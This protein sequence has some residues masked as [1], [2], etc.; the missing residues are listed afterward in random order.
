MIR[1]GVD[2]TN[3]G[4]GGTIKNLSNI[5]NYCEYKK[6]FSFYIWYS[7]NSNIKLIKKRKNVKLIKI[8][9][10]NFLYRLIWQFFFFDKNTDIL[11]CNLIFSPGGYYLGKKKSIVT[12]QNIIP[13]SKLKIN[14]FHE[15][16]FYMKMKILKLIQVYSM[17]KASC[18]IFL[19]K[20]SL[21][22]IKKFT[23]IKK[24]II[25]P[26]GIEEDFFIHKKTNELSLTYV[27][28][29]L[30]YKNYNTLFEALKF[31]KLNNKITINIVG[32]VD[33]KKAP[34]NKMIKY[35]FFKKLNKSSLI[36]LMKKTKVFL[37]LS[38]LESFP[39]TLLE[40][41]ASKNIIICS[42]I[43]P[44]K[45]IVS[46]NASIYVNPKN[47]SKLKLILEEIFNHNQKYDNLIKNAQF[48]SKSK[49]YNLKNISK[50]YFNLFYDINKNKLLTKLED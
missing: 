15:I 26:N 48:E 28:D 7:K 24:K 3:I 42:N 41:M 17:N 34:K 32:K 5:F 13:F 12:S 11:N 44:M 2:A 36:Q 33:M 18:V 20:N 16:F 9:Y 49:E 37:F 47:S 29:D 50:K 31:I 14:N 21:N 1:I 6:D 8:K 23:K 10:N 43:R 19:T 46:N 38:S 39:I 30:P 4:S 27:S 40:G 25:I 45:D 35:R 22:T